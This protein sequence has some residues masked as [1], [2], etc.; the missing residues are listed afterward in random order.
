MSANDGNRMAT[1]ATMSPAEVAELEV[2]DRL[3]YLT[4]EEAGKLLRVGR[5][6]VYKLV[7]SG[8][9]RCKTIGKRQIFARDELHRFVSQHDH[10][11]PEPFT[12]AVRRRLTA[13]AN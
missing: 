9:L 5:H 12:A 6:T 2:L 7:K 3:P 11:A 13:E 4:A 10:I 1:E 8:Q